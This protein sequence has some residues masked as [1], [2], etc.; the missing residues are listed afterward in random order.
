M[1]AVFYNGVD[2]VEYISG[3]RKDVRKVEL[4]AL[5]DTGAT[6]PALPR[7]V[8]E[9]LGLP[10]LD[11][12]VAE[13]AE[14]V[15]RVEL[16]ANAVVKI[17]DRLAQSPVIVRPKGTTPLIGVVVLEQM[18]Y[19]VDLTTGKLIKRLPLMLTARNVGAVAGRPPDS[20]RLDGRKIWPAGGGLLFRSLAGALR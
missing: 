3:R 4:D 17:E 5:V 11:E 6:F 9:V 8:V 14:G 15:K 20:C 19:R 10:K 1:K 13:T 2:Y 12:T 16:M 7:D 18:G